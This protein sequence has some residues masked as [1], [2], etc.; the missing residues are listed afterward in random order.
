MNKFEMRVE[1]MREIYQM[2]GSSSDIES[3]S[4]SLITGNDPFSDPSD[5]WASSPFR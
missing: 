1:Q 5:E 4:T 2:R 3:N